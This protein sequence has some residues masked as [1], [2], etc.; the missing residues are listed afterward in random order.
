MRAIFHLLLSALVGHLAASCAPPTGADDE[1]D[2]EGPRSSTTPS[3]YEACGTTREV[4]D[5]GVTVDPELT[6][7]RDIRTAMDLLEAVAITAESCAVDSDCRAVD[8]ELSC[9][10]ENPEA[11]FGYRYSGCRAIA[12]SRACSFLQALEA[13]EAEVL[14]RTEQP[15]A[16]HNLRCIRPDP[17]CSEGML[18]LCVDGRCALDQ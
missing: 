9:G 8:F 1:T 11:G 17:P 3:S 18:A 7:D 6:C 15:F 4:L 12:L 2:N 5:F 14:C 16:E 13:A 10:P